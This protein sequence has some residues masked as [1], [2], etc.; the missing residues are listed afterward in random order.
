MYRLGV[1]V[2]STT[3]HQSLRFTSMT[4]ITATVLSR[5]AQDWFR[6][7]VLARTFSLKASFATATLAL[8]IPIGA[9]TLTSIKSLTRASPTIN[10][11]LRYMQTTTGAIPLG[12]SLVTKSGT[13]SGRKIWLI[14]YLRA[15]LVRSPLTQVRPKSRTSEKKP[16]KWHAE[17][18]ANIK[19]VI[20]NLEDFEL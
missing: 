3:A 16:Q 6:C 2:T 20:I 14:L 11:S 5:K 8:C 18:S 1:K 13:T 10:R 7:H 12:L 9:I 17:T 4:M 19:I 15:T